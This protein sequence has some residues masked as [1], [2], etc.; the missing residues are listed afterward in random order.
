MPSMTDR[1]SPMRWSDMFMW[2]PVTIDLSWAWVGR[3]A[4]MVRGPSW[5]VGAL[6]GQRRRGLPASGWRRLA[7]RR[8][9]ACGLGG[10]D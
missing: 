2:K 3:L 10:A 1:N 9:A 5:F 6:P 8:R 7:W 4:D